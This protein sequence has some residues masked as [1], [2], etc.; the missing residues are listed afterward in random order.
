[1]YPNFNAEYSRRNFTLEKLSKEME[2]RGYRRTPGTLS[3]KLNGKFPITLNEAKALKSIVAPDIP[4][5]VLFS[6][7][8]S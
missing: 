4:L 8:A 1:M 5:E 7:E 6:E 2:K 3:Q